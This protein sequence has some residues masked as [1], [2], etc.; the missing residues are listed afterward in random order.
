MN[1]IKELINK[2]IKGQIELVEKIKN[3]IQNL[4]LYSF[5]EIN[6]VYKI[7]YIDVY[8]EKT[9]IGKY[10][11]AVTSGQILDIPQIMYIPMKKN[12][13]EYEGRRGYSQELPI[14]YIVSIEL[15]E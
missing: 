12:L 4:P 10:I 5:L 15:I 1:D 9:I 3:D 14:S 7:N 13:T 8:K 11:G 6:K 2:T